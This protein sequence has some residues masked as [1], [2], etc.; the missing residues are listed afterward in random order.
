[1]PTQ[2]A[3]FR[4]GHRARYP[5]IGS[6]SPR[7]S[8]GAIWQYG[9]T[10]VRVTM[11]NPSLVTPSLRHSVTFILEPV[12]YR[13][14][15]WTTQSPSWGFATGT[16]WLLASRQGPVTNMQT[17]C[18]RFRWPDSVP[19][20]IAGAPG[21]MPVSHTGCKPDVRVFRW[22]DSVLGARSSA[23]IRYRVSGARRQ[24]A[25][26]RHLVPGTWRNAWLT[27][28]KPAHRVCK[29]VADSV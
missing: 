12:R 7:V 9:H 26:T 10:A 6:V 22:P 8:N 25:G 18:A 24:V 23:L 20:Q 3:R 1:M 21:G 2:W 17:R 27:L 16:R 11:D 13:P 4:L 5:A 14:T 15:S 28:R 19:G 29:G